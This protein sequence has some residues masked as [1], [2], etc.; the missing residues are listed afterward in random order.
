MAEQSLRTGT[1]TSNLTGFI[2]PR[3]VLL[4]KA[5]L[6]Q[7]IKSRQPTPHFVHANSLELDGTVTRSEHNFFIQRR[8]ERHLNVFRRKSFQK[9]MAEYNRRCV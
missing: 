3:D 9:R 6:A 8:L 2:G 1:S 5:D 7:A 4:V